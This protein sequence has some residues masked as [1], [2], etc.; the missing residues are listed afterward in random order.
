MT[1]ARFE[2]ASFDAPADFSK[3]EFRGIARFDH[4][5]FAQ[6]ASFA[7]TVSYGN[8]SPAH[9]DFGAP[10][11][12]R[13]AEYLGGIWCDSTAFA[14]GTDFSDIQVHGRLWIRRA[15]LGTAPLAA[16]RFTLSFGYT[17]A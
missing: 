10:A 1:D 5:R 16:D 7:G 4:A 2:D 11:D 9:A 17:Y 6:G 8:V 12:F 13:G 3:A 15:R 14:E